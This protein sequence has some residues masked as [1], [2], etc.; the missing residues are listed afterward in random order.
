MVF[1]PLFGPNPQPELDTDCCG[2]IKLISH[3]F[4][5]WVDRPIRYFVEPVIVALNYAE[6]LEYNAFYMVG[7]SGGGW[8]TVLASA[9][10]TRIIGSFPI[11]GTIP[12]YARRRLKDV[13]DFEQ[14][15]PDLYKTAN[16]LEMYVMGSSGEG[17]FQFQV[18]N[19]FDPITFAGSRHQAWESV[20]QDVVEELGKGSFSI[21]LDE[22]TKEHT[23]S[24]ISFQKIIELIE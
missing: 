5:S 23:L 20:I 12:L 14:W 19:L 24:S 3:K 8:A 17:R 4:L 9:L 6:T 11:A 2:P 15:Y 13:G 21:F 16:Y 22:T 10:D 18:M 1:M 7:M